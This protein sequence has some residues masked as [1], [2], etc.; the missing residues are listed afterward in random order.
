M[1]NEAEFVLELRLVIF[2]LDQAAV[3]ARSE[4]QRTI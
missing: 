3:C 4:A 1:D 2:R